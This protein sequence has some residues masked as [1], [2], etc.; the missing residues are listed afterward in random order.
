M[1]SMF[2]VV[3]PTLNAARDWPR[4]S[5]A[6]LKCV[7]PERVLVIDSESNDGTAE[8]AREAGFAIETI[9]RAAFDHGATRQLGADLVKD[10]EIVVYLTQD[11]ILASPDAIEFLVRSFDD[12]Q[13]AAAYGRQLPR[14]GAGP[15]ESHARLFNYPANSRIKTWHD[16]GE[17]GIKAA[18]LSNSFSAFRISALT[19]VGGFPEGVIFGEDMLTAARLLR[20]GYKIAY[21]AEAETYHSHSYG[22]SAEF[23]RNFDI[24][25]MHNREAWLL[26]EFGSA[27]KEGKRFVVSETKFLA[28]KSPWLIPSSMMRIAAK[29]LGYRAGRK[30]AS[31]PVAWKRRVSAN[32]NYWGR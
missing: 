25:V 28:R 9:K 10:S 22:L 31:L 12:P 29:L 6:L 5:S 1:N 30:E 16:R 26:E 32:H 2:M 19:S 7:T 4:F 18:F 15:I 24:G 20:A 11:S 17:M 3:V 27:G 8:L 21:V 23:K 13:V 14:L